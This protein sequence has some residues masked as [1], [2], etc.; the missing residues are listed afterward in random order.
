MVGAGVASR[1]LS[2]LGYPRFLKRLPGD[3]RVGALRTRL[4][5]S[6]TCQ[7]FYP[8]DRGAAGERAPYWRSEAADGLAAYSQMPPARGDASL[9]NRQ[10]LDGQVL[11]QGVDGDLHAQRGR[12]EEDQARALPGRQP[13]ACAATPLS[14]GRPL[15]ERREIQEQD[16]DMV[17]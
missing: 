9:D 6:L 13:D 14:A 7:V 11:S 1:L 17:L 2:L 15:S 16:A 4:P 12:G 5:S 10:A 3:Y 8:V